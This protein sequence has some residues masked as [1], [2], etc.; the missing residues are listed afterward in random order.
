MIHPTAIVDQSAQLAENVEVGPYSI[1][2]PEVEIDS[3]TIV[4]AH[5]V[6]KGPT[7]IGKDNRIH[8]F[9]SIGDIPQDLSFD[10]NE[11][12]QLIIGDRNS[13]REYVSIHRAISVDDCVTKIGDDNMLMAHVHIGHNCILGNNIVI[14]NSANLAGHVEVDDWAILSGFTGIHQF[15]RIGAHAIVGIQSKVTQDILPFLMYA[16]SSPK[17]INAKGLQRRGF[18]KQEILSIRRAFKTIYRKGYSKEQIDSE[19]TAMAV[20]SKSV[21]LMLDFIRSSPRGIAR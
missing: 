14:V 10:E 20:E 7:K 4:E 2:G 11:K 9:S 19:L 17:T 6:I 5:V 18:E 15:C 1:I 3:G 21:Q 13:I 16:E 12:T 8:Q